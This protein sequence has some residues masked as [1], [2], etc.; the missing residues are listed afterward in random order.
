MRSLAV[1][2]IVL[3]SGALGDES[4]PAGTVALEIEAG[5]TAPVTA[6]PGSS[7]LC[8]DTSVVAPEFT[9]DGNG[10]VLRA[11]KAGSTLCGVWLAGKPGGLY[12]V[13]V[14]G[15]P[16]RDAGHDGSGRGAGRR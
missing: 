6:A 5:K 13:R 15:A 14:V 3:A 12:R 7:I 11:Q 8:D 1:F 16:T 2:L 10:L 4:D 9:P